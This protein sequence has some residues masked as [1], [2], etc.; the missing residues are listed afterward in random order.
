MTFDGMHQYACDAAWRL[1]DTRDGSEQT[2]K[3]HPC[4]VRGTWPLG[5]DELVQVPVNTGIWYGVLGIRI[6][7]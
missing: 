3:Q 4:G 2:L 5:I 7:P 6:S 1:L